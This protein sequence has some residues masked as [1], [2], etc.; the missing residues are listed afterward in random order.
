MKDGKCLVPVWFRDSGGGINHLTEVERCALARIYWRAR[1][2]EL[3]LLRRATAG[4]EWGTKEWSRAMAK[5]GNSRR[6]QMLEQIEDLGLYLLGE[7]R[8]EEAERLER[9]LTAYKKKVGGR[10]FDSK[11]EQ[12]QEGQQG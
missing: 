9:L 6:Y 10:N 4:L 2:A 8:S 7:E 11:G 3:R 1:N 12:Q 5:V